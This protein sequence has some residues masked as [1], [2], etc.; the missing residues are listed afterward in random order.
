LSL[1]IAG[2]GNDIWIADS[3]WNILG[4]M[5][6]E[7]TGSDQTYYTASTRLFLK[8]GSRKLRLQSRYAKY[9]LNWLEIA[10]TGL[11]RICDFESDWEQSL[12]GCVP[13]KACRADST[14]GWIKQTARPG[15]LQI[16]NSHVRSGKSAARFELAKSDSSTWPNVRSEVYSGPCPYS[17]MWFGFST[18]SPTNVTGDGNA[19]IF[20]QLHGT[21]DACDNSRSP[22][23]DLRVEADSFRSVILWDADS[24]N[25]NTTK[26]GQIS[27]NLGKFT[28]SVWDDWVM[29]IRFAYDNT[30]IVEMWRNGIKVIDRQ[31]APNC[32]NDFYRPYPKFGI[33]KW[34]WTPQW[35]S[36]SP[37]DVL[38]LYLD[39]IRMGGPTSN[40]GEVAP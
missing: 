39:N 21:D 16:D 11:Y 23:L 34:G 36:Y 1:R 8:A 10:P 3:A 28:P 22:V 9:S 38:V 35:A 32:Y 15:S 30:G 2:S 37:Y 17:E 27:Y 25:T 31:N 19:H 12:V 26:D 14:C 20:F 4:K 18:Y 6:F 40:Y 33:Y 29:H 13:W 5:R 24:C 7:P